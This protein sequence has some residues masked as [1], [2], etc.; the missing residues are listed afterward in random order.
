[1][2][3]QHLSDGLSSLLELGWSTAIAL[4]MRSTQG[5]SC[6]VRGMSGKRGR[7][8]ALQVQEG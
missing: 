4:P 1:M 8:A 6:Q 2:V 3:V 7:L 5:R